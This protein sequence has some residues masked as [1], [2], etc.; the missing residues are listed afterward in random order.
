MRCRAINSSLRSASFAKVFADTATVRATSC[1]GITLRYGGFSPRARIRCQQS[2]SGPSSFVD[3][4][5]IA[6]RSI[7]SFL[8]LP[9][10]VKNRPRGDFL[11]PTNEEL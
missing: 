1:V 2:P 9:G 3:V 7:G 10:Q 6:S 8:L 11:P 4:F 5:G